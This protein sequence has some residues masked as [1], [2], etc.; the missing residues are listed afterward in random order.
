MTD[1]ERRGVS[2]RRERKSERDHF[3]SKTG[4]KVVITSLWVC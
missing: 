3:V 1:E 4:N 2:E